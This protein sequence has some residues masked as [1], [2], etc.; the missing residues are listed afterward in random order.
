[1][2]G[3]TIKIILDKVYNKTIPKPINLQPGYDMKHVVNYQHYTDVYQIEKVV[4]I[5]KQYDNLS[6]IKPHEMPQQW[7]CLYL[8]LTSQA[9]LWNFM[10]CKKNWVFT[11]T[12]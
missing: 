2:P 9:M 7:A 10:L 12:V 3:Q 4:E 8:L 11:N 1:M 5:E 6:I